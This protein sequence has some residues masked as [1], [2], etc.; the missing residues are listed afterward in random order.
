MPRTD[1]AGEDRPRWWGSTAFR[2]TLLH[3][4]LTLLGT[5]ALS[6]V[7]WWATTGFALRQVAQEVERDSG[8]LAQAMRI[9]GPRSA[10]LSI[11]ARIAADRSGTQYYLLAGPDGTRL[12]GNLAEAPRAPGWERLRLS[13]PGV[14]TELLALG[15]LLP[16]RGVLVVGRDIAPV[17][18]LEGFLLSAAGWV[19]GA[20][21]LLG[22]GGG[23]LIGRGVTRRAAVMGAAL[24]R[25]EAGEIGHRLPVRPGGDEFD[26]LARR[27]NTAL[28]RVQ[29]LMQAL[30]QVTDD[31]AHDLRTPLNRLRQRLDAALRNAQGEE[32]W[33]AATEG[34]IADCEKLLDIFA[35]LLR[36]AQVESGARRAAFAR[37]DLSAVAET[38]AEVHAP[39]AEER[40]QTLE[41][42]VAPGLVTLGDR[43][44]VTQMLSNLLDNAVK[45]GREGGRIALR[46]AARPEGGAVLM[47]EDD[48]PGI[49]AEARELVLRR[50]HRL[51]GA[52]STPGTGLGLALVAAVAE[53]HGMV[54]RL[55]GAASGLRVTLEVPAT[56]TTG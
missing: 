34:A 30:R 37:F 53:L 38:V 40:G 14:E 39:A 32:A 26:Q 25:V 42:D 18:Q 9:G 1:L 2:V 6:A 28:D 19:G 49:P 41:T 15:T 11:E 22:L 47:V 23:L 27:I 21:L 10:A 5:A 4:V 44:L 54:L 56:P 8:L 29:G 55:G 46:L 20:A 17:R 3:L 43:D 33:R 52:R 13:G 12:A 50:F 31:I 36:I 24:A 45:H 7:A 16:G 51:D 35:A 48:G